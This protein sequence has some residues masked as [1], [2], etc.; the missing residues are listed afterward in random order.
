MNTVQFNGYSSHDDYRALN[1]QVKLI[2]DQSK[3][4]LL[5]CEHL[6]RGQINA[7]QRQRFGSA[8]QGPC[9][10][11]VTEK[12][13]L[14]LDG[15]QNYEVAL[16]YT[17][18]KDVLSSNVITPFNVSDVLLGRGYAMEYF[19][20]DVTYDVKTR[21]KNF[22]KTIKEG[23]KFTTPNAEQI[24][25]PII[26]SFID[27]NYLPEQ[28]KTSIPKFNMVIALTVQIVSSYN[29]ISNNILKVVNFSPDANALTGMDKIVKQGGTSAAAALLESYITKKKLKND[30]K[31]ATSLSGA[32]FAH[33]AYDS[34]MAAIEADPSREQHWINQF[35]LCLVEPMI[36]TRVEKGLLVHTVKYKSIEPP[37]YFNEKEF[38]IEK[39]N[40]SIPQAYDANKIARSVRGENDSEKAIFSRIANFP[41]TVPYRVGEA[42]AMRANYL[43]YFHGCQR[44]FVDADKTVAQTVVSDFLDAL[45]M[46]D[47]SGE[48][49]VPHHAS[50]IIGMVAHQPDE[51]V[52]SGFVDL[53]HLDYRYRNSPMK[54]VLY[55]YEKT[56]ILRKQFDDSTLVI[57]FK[58]IVHPEG[59]YNDMCSNVNYLGSQR[60]IFHNSYRYRYVFE[61]PLVDG[62]KEWIYG[63]HTKDPD[64]AVQLRSGYQMT[65]LHAFYSNFK[66]DDKADG[67]SYNLLD[68]KEVLSYCSAASL[69]TILRC[70]YK[71]TG[72]RPNTYLK[73]YKFR[74]LPIFV[75]GMAKIGSNVLLTMKLQPGQFEAVD[76]DELRAIFDTADTSQKIEIVSANPEVFSKMSGGTGFT[77][78]VSTGVP[79]RRMLVPETEDYKEE[80]EEEEE[81][82]RVL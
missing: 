53:Q 35:N 46:S 43:R 58:V 71:F 15:L 38:N 48:V 19:E 78:N 33:E 45:V 66:C 54:I 64:E 10:S 37:L 50:R 49:F 47:Y 28:P 18:A 31:T 67:W 63:L 76:I 68:A 17:M 23:V 60:A 39:N 52:K 51:S 4:A 2:S 5:I 56:E 79:G 41:F 40:I 42:C 22:K 59:K 11:I 21:G 70:V 55:S 27:T 82:T 6:T 65:N 34:L 20:G 32:K 13:Q 73:Y 14:I 26:N 3:Q 16:A 7:F 61:L 57:D 81:K 29:F 72:V 30:V 1:S 77:F 36:A 74:T 24:V 12:T 44:V 9:D 69:L 8:I 62:M 25:L 80:G 75:K